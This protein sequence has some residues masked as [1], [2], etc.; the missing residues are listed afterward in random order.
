V[1]EFFLQKD[2]C[3]YLIHCHVTRPLD[4]HLHPGIPGAARQFTQNNQLLDLASVGG[5]IETT[6]AEGVP[7][8]EDEV[9]SGG[10]FKEAVILGEERVLL[11]PES[12]PFREKRATPAD[13]PEDS[14]LKAHPSQ[15]LQGQTAVDG[16]ETDPVLS[17][18]LNGI[19]DLVRRH[20][21]QTARVTAQRFHRRLVDGYRSHGDGAAIH[22]RP[23]DPVQAAPGGKVHDGVRTGVESR[24]QFFHFRRHRAVR[25][26][27]S[28]DEIG[29][30][31]FFPCYFPDFRGGDA[32]AGFSQQS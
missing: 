12:H 13:D 21:V 22:D 10:Y 19:E 20:P 24:R 3:L 6:R 23:A 26:R 16:D 27:S 25:V 2:V 28:A 17:V 1:A 8:A 11:S 31:A 4:Y 7:E 29:L 15:A 5:V 30:E 18:L 14:S 9:V 32:P